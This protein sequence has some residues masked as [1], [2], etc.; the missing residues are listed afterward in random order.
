MNRTLPVL[1]L[2][3]LLVACSTSKP[4]VQPV[5]RSIDPETD[6]T[7]VGAVKGAARDGVEEAEEGARV[8][9]I[10]GRV[11]GVIAAVLGGPDEDMFDRYRRTRD[12]AEVI[13]AVI[14]AANGATEGAKEGFDLDT[15]F[16]ELHAIEGIEVIRPVPEEIEVHLAAAPGDELLAKIAAVLTAHEP[17]RFDVAAAGSLAIEVREALIERGIPAANIDAHRDD[18]VQGVII[19]VRMRG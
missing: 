2:G 19:L 11:A 18:E 10:V 17:R 3:F 15:Q 9:R 13:G 7:V 5:A 1:L 6:P 16:A 8:G 14:G 12:A 4:A